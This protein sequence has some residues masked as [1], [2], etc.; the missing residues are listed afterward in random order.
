MKLTFDFY[1]EVPLYMQLRNQII[2]AISSGELREGDRLPT[3]RALSDETGVNSMTISKA[4]QFLKQEGY[5]STDRRAG[6]VVKGGSVRKI[7]EDLPE[8]LRIA[9]CELKLSGM[10]DEGILD[11]V[12]EILKGEN[13]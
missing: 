8:R 10:D 6:T 3:V 7:P 1:S 5:I 4:Y 11:L 9:V 12:R 13:R 2:L